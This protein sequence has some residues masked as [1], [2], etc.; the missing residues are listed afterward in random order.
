MT[1]NKVCYDSLSVV[2]LLGSVKY[3]AVLY[4]MWTVLGPLQ[5]HV[6]QL[7]QCTVQW[8]YTKRKRD[9]DIHNLRCCALGDAG[10]D[11]QVH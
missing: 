7:H 4:S 5:V 10:S 11:I 2:R 9:N 3:E 8:L 6:I 1:F